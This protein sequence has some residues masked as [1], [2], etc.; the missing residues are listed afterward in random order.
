[1]ILIEKMGGQVVECA[2]MID[3]PDIGGRARLEQRGGKVFALCEF[4][5][6]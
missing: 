3:L 6:D 2:F 1:C 5:G 4:E